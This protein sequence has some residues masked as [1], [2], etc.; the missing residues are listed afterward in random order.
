MKGGKRILV[1]GSTDL[2]KF[3]KA[4]RKDYLEACTQLGRAIASA[5]HTIVLGSGSDDDNKIDR[6]IVEGANAVGGDK[7]SVIAYAAPKKEYPFQKDVE[8]FSQLAFAWPLDQGPSWSRVFQVKNADAVIVIGGGEGT[9]QTGICAR[10]LECPVLAIPSFDGGAER[11]WKDIHTEYDET[12]GL[13][14]DA[15]KLQAPWDALRADL[16]VR[17][18]DRLLEAKASRSTGIWDRV[19]ALAAVVALMGGWLALFCAPFHPRPAPFLMIL[20]VSALLGTA[21]RALTRIMSEPGAQISTA[22]LVTE[23]AT[24]LALS[25]GLMILYFSGGLTISGG[26]DFLKQLDDDAGFRR[27]AVVFSVLGLA[28]AFTMERAAQKISGLL[29]QFSGGGK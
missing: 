17:M 25:F 14:E 3:D 24:G 29:D 5:R 1:V 21:M 19:L 11:V 4:P 16:A 28:G 27:N 12:P 9:Y 22:R 26:A 18:V 20:C 7:H 8:K 10:A 6:F 15:H 13:A 23:A 2:K